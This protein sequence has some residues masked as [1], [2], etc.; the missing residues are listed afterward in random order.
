[1]AR[2]IVGVV[3]DEG[4]GLFGVRRFQH[5]AEFTR[6]PLRPDDLEVRRAAR[7][8]APAREIGRGAAPDHVLIDLTHD[9]V[10]RYRWV[11]GVP[12][13]AEE[14]RFFAGVADEQDRAA[15]PVSSLRAGKRFGDF[16][17]RDRP[18]AV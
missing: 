10:D 9:R 1:M 2:S 17:D 5:L 7:A 14:S 13:R 4:Q 8:R 3:E 18:G 15:W 11:I 16:D 12:P 6:N